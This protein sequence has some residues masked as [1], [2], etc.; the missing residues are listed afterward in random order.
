[1]DATTDDHTKWSQKEKD[2]YHMML[3]VASKIWQKW[4]YET[5][6][7]TDRESSLVVAKGEETWA[8]DGLGV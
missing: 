2:K 3:Y 4:T 6:R 8:R 7:L 1:M 5:E